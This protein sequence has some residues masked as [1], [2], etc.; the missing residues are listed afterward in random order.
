MKA[1]FLIDNPHFALTT[2]S[3]CRTS[4][5]LTQPVRRHKHKIGSSSQR[6]CNDPVEWPVHQRRRSKVSL[7]FHVLPL[8]T[9]PRPRD[10]LRRPAAHVQPSDAVNGVDDAAVAFDLENGGVE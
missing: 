7:A 1:R 8:L 9:I 10:N 3:R 2:G 6:L 5:T 4:H